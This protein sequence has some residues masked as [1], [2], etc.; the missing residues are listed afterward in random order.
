[1]RLLMRVEAQRFTPE[2]ASDKL[3]PNRTE[4][5]ALLRYCEALQRALQCCQFASSLFSAKNLPR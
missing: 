5:L 3:I 4:D 2:D 1:M